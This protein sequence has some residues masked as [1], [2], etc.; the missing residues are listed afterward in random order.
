MDPANQRFTGK[1]SNNGVENDFIAEADTEHGQLILKTNGKTVPLKMVNQ[2]AANQQP[3]A[4]VLEKAVAQDGGGQVQIVNGKFFTLPVPPGWKHEEMRGET[5][6]ISPDGKTA[7]GLVGRPTRATTPE[8][9][10][11]EFFQGYK[12]TDMK[13]ISSQPFD[14]GNGQKGLDALISFTGGDGV[15]RTGAIKVMLMQGPQGSFGV[16]VH[17]ATPKENESNLKTAAGLAMQIKVLNQ[18]PQ[19]APGGA[20]A[21]LQ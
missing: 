7:Y 13:I 2:Q 11:Q 16:L 8:E 4:N 1:W 20:Q 6:V 5:V 14:A 10:A 18:Q 3:P 15:V 17:A 12:V 19:P 9:F 21:G